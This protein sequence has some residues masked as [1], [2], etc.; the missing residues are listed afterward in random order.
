MFI[1]LL[2]DGELD[3]VTTAGTPSEAAELLVETKNITDAIKVSVVAPFEVSTDKSNWS[4]SATLAIDEDRFYLR[5]NAQNTGSYQSSITLASGTYTN[6][7]AECTGTV[8]TELG[9]YEDFETENPDG[10]Y[11][12]HQQQCRYLWDFSNAA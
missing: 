12:D 1:D 10:T 3:F 8:T 4:T 5:L 7:N 2:F 11:N 6:D 9:F